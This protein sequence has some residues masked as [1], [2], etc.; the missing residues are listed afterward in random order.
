MKPFLNI[1]IYLIFFRLILDYGV[2]IGKLDRKFKMFMQKQIKNT[3]SPGPAL[4]NI[5][6]KWTNWS[7]FEKKDLLCNSTLEES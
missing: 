1:F 3:E 2:Q 5:L 4:I 6:I 7:P